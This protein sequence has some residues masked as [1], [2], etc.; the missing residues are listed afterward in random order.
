MCFQRNWLILTKEKAD[1][2][3]MREHWK[4]FDRCR[5]TSLEVVEFA[6]RVLGLPDELV[7]LP[8]G[9]TRVLHS[10]GELQPGL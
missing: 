8:A 10:V 9:S 6:E 5:N 1:N 3:K 4:L 2:S 7:Q